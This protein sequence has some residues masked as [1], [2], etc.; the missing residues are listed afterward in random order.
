MTLEC[1]PW[2]GQKGPVGVRELEGLSTVRAGQGLG[3]WLGGSEVARVNAHRITAVGVSFSGSP[4]SW[5]GGSGELAKT[6]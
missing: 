1:S 3:P 2:V 4:A 5:Q 6:P